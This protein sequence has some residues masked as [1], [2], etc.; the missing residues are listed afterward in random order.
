M[1]AI[2]RIL[3]GPALLGLALTA[4]E[5][6]AAEPRPAPPDSRIGFAESRSGFRIDRGESGLR[7][8]GGAPAALL[9]GDG[10]RAGEEHVRV[11]LLDGSSVLLQKDAAAAFTD[12]RT[13][14]VREGEVVVSIAGN[15]PLEVVAD[16]L[17]VEPVAVPDATESERPSESGAP[18]R[19]ETRLA[20]VFRPEPDRVMVA[21]FDRPFA[22]RT[23]P[24]RKGLAVVGVE[25]RVTFLRKD[26]EWVV[27]Q[28]EE[29]PVAET[30]EPAVSEPKKGKGGFDE[31]EVV[32][33]RRRRS[34]GGG[35][36]GGVAVAPGGIAGLTPL[37]AFTVVTTGVTTVVTTTSP[38][39]ET[40][41]E[42]SPTNP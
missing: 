36:G 20:S 42:T 27:A 8:R 18:A 2:L 37:G 23:G 29:S 38:D 35:Y 9:A 11:Q 4:P 6:R 14:A 39:E 28:G 24:E 15:S 21:G 26:G 10:L 40:Q 16:G 12:P 30:A 32:T 3:S 34:G 33:R 7:L 22:V 25:E 5:A 17:F 19:A 31:D 1:N 13:L 41:P